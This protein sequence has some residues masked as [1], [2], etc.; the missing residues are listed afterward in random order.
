MRITTFDQQGARDI[1]AADLSA[2]LS[3]SQMVWVDMT[4][5]TEDD[6]RVMR[7]QAGVTVVGLFVATAAA[8]VE[9]SQQVERAAVAVG[10]GFGQRALDG[11]TSFGAAQRDRYRE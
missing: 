1:P 4:G 5:P 9:L 11:F 2:A 3:S 6:V 10:A 7:A 8:R